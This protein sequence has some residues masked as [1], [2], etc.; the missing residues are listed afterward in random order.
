[1]RSSSHVRRLAAPFVIAL[2]GLIAAGCS[3]A[4]ITTPQ[5]GFGQ[6][7]P[8]EGAGTYTDISPA[9][10]DQLFETEDF[11]FVNVHIPYEGEIPATDAFI[12]FDQV[13]D[14]LG[15]FPQEK[16]AQIVLYCRSGSMSAIAARTLVEE[17]YTN[18]LNLDGGFRAWDAQGFPFSE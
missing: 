18:V 1:M 3:P 12:P 17:G 10:L 11:F 4:A 5:D 7:I 2:A 15:E 9:E 6:V 13:R 14:K 16:D 8:V